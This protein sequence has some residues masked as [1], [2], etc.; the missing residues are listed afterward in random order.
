MYHKKHIAI[1]TLWFPTEKKPSYGVFVENQAA[2]LAEVHDVTVILVNLSMVPYTKKTQ[3]RGFRVLEVGAFFL[4]SKTTSFIDF[5]SRKY[6]KAFDLV[7][8][9]QPVDII[10]SHSY[11][12]AFPGQ[13]IADRRSVPH[14]TTIH[15]TT[16]LADMLPPWKRKYLQRNLAKADRVISVGKSL[17]HHLRSTYE[18]KNGVLIP[19]GIDT[20]FFT[21]KTD[22]WNHQRPF[23]F[24]FVGSFDKRKGL[25]EIIEAFALL[26]DKTAELHFVGYHAMEQP[27]RDLVAQL[28]IDDR[29]TFYG[30]L[31]NQQLPAVYHKCDG[32]VSFSSLETFGVT[33]VEAMSCGLPVIYSPSGGPE[34][35][36]AQHC[37]ICVGDRTIPALSAAM[38]ALIDTYHTYDHSAIRDHVITHYSSAIVTEKLCDL[39]DLIVE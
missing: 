20:S 39:Y 26:S 3:R 31:S 6:L 38:Q 34:H 7:Q 22:I 15:D 27:M 1:I 10:H 2:A 28:Q 29:V 18:L 4:P 5:R 12:S 8:R 32:Y 30:N 21:L 14:V 13:Y 23:R 16:V 33:V 36:V 11:M 19:N 35:T 17:H 37:G 9:H 24:L 25:L